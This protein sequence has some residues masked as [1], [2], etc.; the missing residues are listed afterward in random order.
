MSFADFYPHLTA[1]AH[2]LIDLNETIDGGNFV[3]EQ[4]ALFVDEYS[5]AYKSYSEL[6]IAELEQEIRPLVALPFTSG[7]VGD[8]VAAK[9]AEAETIK[10]YLAALNEAKTLVGKAG[11]FRDMEHIQAEVCQLKADEYDTRSYLGEAYLQ[12]FRIHQGRSVFWNSLT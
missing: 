2:E 10:A 3:P 7:I 4:A 11:F 6:R 1:G 12:L 9:Y 8:Q 5:Q